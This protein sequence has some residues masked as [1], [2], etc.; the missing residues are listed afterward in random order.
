MT[1]FDD[2]ERRTWAGRAEAYAASFAGLCAYPV[3]MLL[4]AAEVRAG[5]RVLDIGTG[6]GTVARAAAGR[7]AKVT[8]V[9]AEPGMVALAAR[10]APGA[11]VRVAVLPDL[12]FADGEFDAVVGNFVLNHVGQPHVALTELRRVTR[13]GGRV[14][15]TIWT[16]PTAAGQ[17]LFGRALQA[18]GV[19]RPAH[20]PVLAPEDN[21]E[22][23][24]GGL[25]GLL[26]A[27]GFADAACRT[28]AWN[29]RATAE[30]WWS[31]PAAGVASIGQVVVSQT[32]E[33][34]AEIKRHYDSISAE[35]AG[36]GGVLALPQLALLGY[37]QV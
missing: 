26:G 14:A 11:N 19:S 25:A 27:A 6:T 4:D 5:T 36:P 21:F 29:H 10:V 1:V 17:A 35:F 30:E 23:T 28:L 18:A 34:V 33:V 2:A 22:R 7:G 32:A 37:G 13:P 16:A 8:A 12:P 3:P 31:G 20:L 9:D 15:L 24:A